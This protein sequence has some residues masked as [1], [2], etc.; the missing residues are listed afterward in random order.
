MEL[1]PRDV[2]LARCRA[3]AGQGYVYG[4]YFRRIITEA[5][6]EAKR[7]Q[8][9]KPGLKKNPY[10]SDG[11]NGHAYVRRARK[12]LGKIAGDCVGLH[13]AAYWD[14]GTGKITYAY[15]GRKDHSADGMLAAATKKGA[16]ASMPDVPGMGVHRSG[17]VGVYIGNGKVIESR[18]VNYGVV[19]TNLKDRGW[20]SWFEVP[21]VDYSNVT[22]EDFMLRK[23]DKGEAVYLYQRAL[24]RL[25]KNVGTGKW[26]DLHEKDAA[27]NP[28]KT[29]ADGSFGDFMVTLTKQVQAEFRLEQT[30]VVDGLLYGR[31]TAALPSGIPQSTLDALHAKYSELEGKNKVLA[32]DL[33][34]IGGAIAKAAT[35]K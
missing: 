22:K 1:V 3:R 11:E 29:G 35:Y 5:T 7:V 19:I 8:Y 20:T 25:G 14:D 28:V 16:I 24:M 21:Y 13:K 27:G 9:T 10:N 15:L 31:I 18:G 30:G 26:N 12:W 23:G 4:E 2:F 32:A 34:M 6:L 33:K 17:H